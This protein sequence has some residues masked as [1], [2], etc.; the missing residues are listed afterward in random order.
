[1]TLC[2]ALHCTS[3]KFKSLIK[4]LLLQTIIIYSPLFCINS[5]H[6]LCQ[7]PSLAMRLLLLTVAIEPRTRLS[8][9]IAN[10]RPTNVLKL[11]LIFS[12]CKFSQNFPIFIK[13]NI[14]FFKV[15]HYLEKVF[16]LLFPFIYSNR[17][18]QV[19]FYIVLHDM[20]VYIQ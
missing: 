15:Y 6:A 4:I 7:M 13:Q 3:Q 12:I 11:Y 5:S 19:N 8:V 18:Q 10:Y 9:A 14:L 16:F 1:M 20:K 17:G 2:I